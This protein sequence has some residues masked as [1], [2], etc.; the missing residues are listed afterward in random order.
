M[1]PYHCCASCIHYRVKK[2]EGKTAY[3]CSRLGFGTKPD[4]QFNCWTPKESTK[5]L[6]EKRLKNSNQ[7]K[8]SG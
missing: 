4:Y 6:M 3:L 1:N 7:E 2:E 5:L 8:T